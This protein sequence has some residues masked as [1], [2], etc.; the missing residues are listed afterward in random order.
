LDP[1]PG[2]PLIEITDVLA[3]LPRCPLVRVPPDGAAMSG[4]SEADFDGDGVTDRGYAWMETAG[5]GTTSWYVGVDLAHGPASAVELLGVG[6]SYASVLG[7][8]DLD[9]SLGQTTNRSELVAV[10]GSAAGVVYVAM[11]GVDDGGCAFQFDDGT[12][13]PFTVTVGSA[14]G[15][16]G[17][18]RC[19]GG[20]GSQFLVMLTARTDDKVTYSTEDVRIERSGPTSLE[21]GAMLLG[22]LPVGSDALTAYHSASCGSEVWVGG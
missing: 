18:L 9:F 10:V 15:A 13:A 11:F 22:E 17:G 6:S 2:G 7:A 4:S 12:V 8:Y 5:D 1:E 14:L 19:D 16:L 21:R 3:E 20:A